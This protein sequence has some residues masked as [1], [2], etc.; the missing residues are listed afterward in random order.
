M[1]SSCKN[2]NVWKCV[3]PRCRHS[4]KPENIMDQIPTVVVDPM[5]SLMCEYV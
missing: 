1:K 4:G 2:G 5:P 3:D